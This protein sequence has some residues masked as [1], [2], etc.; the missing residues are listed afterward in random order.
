MLVSLLEGHKYKNVGETMYCVICQTMAPI[1]YLALYIDSNRVIVTVF[2]YLLIVISN[3][4]W[5]NRFS[6]SNVFLI[7]PIPNFFASIQ[8]NQ[9]IVW[10]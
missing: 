2:Y 4:L 8:F 6:I 1:A 7:Y 9:E 5:I 10:Y 3:V